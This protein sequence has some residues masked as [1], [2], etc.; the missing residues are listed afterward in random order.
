MQK[1]ELHIM[2]ERIKHSLE[3]KITKTKVA[4]DFSYI[5]EQLGLSSE[6]AKQLCDNIFTL[7]LSDKLLPDIEKEILHIFENI[8]IQVGDKETNLIKILHEKMIDRV[9]IITSQVTQYFE[10]VSGKAIDYGAG[11]GQITQELHDNLDLDIEGV[12]IRLY[13]NQN[14]TVPITLLNKSN[15]E[16]A[17]KTYEAA[18]LTNVLHHERDNEKILDELDRIVRRK[19]VIIET[20]PVGETEEAMEQDKDRTFMNDYLHNRLFHNDDV[21]VPGSYETPKKWVNRFAQHG[22]KLISEKDLEFDQPIFRI[23]HY[24]F[25]FER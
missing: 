11:D 21:P 6:K 10:D 14:V 8:K 12:D 1:E 7:L 16:V 9:K 13:K 2:K 3:N 4:N 22:W 15:V 5:F 23:R 18:L 24:L 20:V 25:I 19:L 17:D